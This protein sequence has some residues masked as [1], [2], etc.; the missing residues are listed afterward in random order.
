V[1]PVLPHIV[2]LQAVALM[3]FIN[4]FKTQPAQLIK[5]EYTEVTA[6]NIGILI[7]PWI[8]LLIGWLV[9]ILILKSI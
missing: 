2:F 8:T 4:L 7:A 3:M 5:K 6:A 1:F 9:K